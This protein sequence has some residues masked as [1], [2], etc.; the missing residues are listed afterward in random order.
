MNELRGFHIV[1]LVKENYRKI[2]VAKK[3]YKIGEEWVKSK[4]C[5]QMASDTWDWNKDS[6]LFHEK[7]GFETAHTLVHFI[8]DI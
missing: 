8:K 7:L 3:L 6:I 5:T 1:I 2:G 4:D